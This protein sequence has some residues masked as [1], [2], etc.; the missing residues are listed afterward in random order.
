MK[1]LASVKVNNIRTIQQQAFHLYFVF[2]ESYKATHNGDYTDY[3]NFVR[4]PTAPSSA[5]GR[6]T[7]LELVDSSGLFSS[8]TANKTRITSNG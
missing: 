2:H 8:F 1:V 4:P 7:S 6:A 3:L 5:G